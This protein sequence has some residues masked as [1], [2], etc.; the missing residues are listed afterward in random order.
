MSSA[1]I[2]VCSCR[3][4]SVARFTFPALVLRQSRVKMQGNMKK[5]LILTN[6]TFQK[7]QIPC[8]S[9]ELALALQ[10]DEVFLVLRERSLIYATLSSVSI[11]RYRGRKFSMR[12][13]SCF[14]DNHVKTLFRKSICGMTVRV[15]QR[16]RKSH[17]SISL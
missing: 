12:V 17:M 15:F 9:T 14:C 6:N 8:F 5:L 4:G 16:P 2:T 11:N 10:L 7:C 3:I 1:L 13:T